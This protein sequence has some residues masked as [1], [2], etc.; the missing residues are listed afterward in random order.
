MRLVHPG[1]S[2]STIICGYIN[3]YIYVC[4]DV[5]WHHSAIYSRH[6]TSSKHHHHPRIVNQHHHYKITSPA[7]SVDCKQIYY[8]DN[9][10]CILWHNNNFDFWFLVF[11]RVEIPT[12]AKQESFIML[13]FHTG[14]R[15][16]ILIFWFIFICL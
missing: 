2:T 7:S 4:I 8:V 13:C 15:L 16:E 1:R 12:S 5:Y 6:V 10:A 14:A 11:S 3:T 9:R